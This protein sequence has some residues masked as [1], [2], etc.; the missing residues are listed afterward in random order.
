LSFGEKNGNYDT[1][2]NYLT[3]FL[4]RLVVSG[5]SAREVACWGALDGVGW[6]WRGRGEEFKFFFRRRFFGM[7]NTWILFLSGIL[8][9]A[10]G[11]GMRVYEPA[12]GVCAK[13]SDYGMLSEVGYDCVEESV[14]RFLMPDRSEVEFRRMLEEQREAGARVVSCN[15]FFPGHLRIVGDTT[16]HDELVAWSE[17]ALRRAQMAGIRY[18]VLGSGHS[19]NVPRGFSKE[20]ATAQFVDLCRRLGPVAQRYQVVIVVEPLNS[21]ETNLI[22]TVA[23]GAQIIE[24][25]NHPNIRLLADLY[26][27][28]REGE[29]AE[30]LVKYGKYIRHCHIAER[31]ERSAPGVRGD[32]FTA[33]FA[34][35]KKIRYKGALSIECRWD[36]M[37]EQALPALVCMKEQFKQLK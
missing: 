5:F 27:M 31:E 9:L 13:I 21:E 10:G 17:T 12:Y 7:G 14:G 15:G 32:D 35:L 4:G 18:I 24:A 36:G 34:A 30:H 2:K 11:C 25:V 37:E 26:H 33:Y 22:N 29:P 20:K 28:M 19:R 6:L 23:E 8:V 1:M 3:G 16:M